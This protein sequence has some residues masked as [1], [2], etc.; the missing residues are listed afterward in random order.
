MSYRKYSNELRGAHFFSHCFA[1][2]LI[3]VRRSFG[4]GAYLSMYGKQECDTFSLC[5]SSHSELSFLNSNERRGACLGAAPI[6]PYNNQCG[7]YLSIY[8]RYA[9][10]IH[11][12][13]MLRRPHLIVLRNC[14]IFLRIRRQNASI[15]CF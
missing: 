8:G 3:W 14:N 5:K 1:A 9:I 13:G 6:S 10:P 4:C 7:A 15:V 11:T 12:V 2:A